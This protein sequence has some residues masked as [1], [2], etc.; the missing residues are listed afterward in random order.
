MGT[1]TEEKWGDWGWGE[2]RDP[3]GRKLSALLFLQRNMIKRAPS[4]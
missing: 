3:G 2:K 1:Q 4:S